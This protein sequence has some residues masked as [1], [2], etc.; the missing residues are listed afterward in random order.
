MIRARETPAVLGPDGKQPLAVLH[1]L[2]VLDVDAH[3]FAVVLGVD[4]VHQL[5]RLDDAEHLPFFHRRSDI[6][7]RGGPRLGRAVERPDDGRLY[8]GELDFRLAAFGRRR[9][10]RE[11]R[12]RGRGASHDDSGYR[13]HLAGHRDGGAGRVLADLQPQSLVFDFEFRELVL[14]DELENLFQLVEV[15]LCVT[16]NGGNYGFRRNHKSIFP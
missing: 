5:H 3:D 6:D 13:G 8:N 10:V 11:R 2:A 16:V 1:R 4:F 14:T 15:H 9:C 12:R 7:E